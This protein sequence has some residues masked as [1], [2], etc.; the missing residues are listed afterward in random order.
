MVRLTSCRHLS[1]QAATVAA[2]LFSAPTALVAQ[3]AP[4]AQA[5]TKLPKGPRA[6]MLADWYRVVNVSSPAVS[7][8]GKRVAM[9]VTKAVEA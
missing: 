2:L 6:M 8:D 7:P 5:A 9:T 1:R 3:P 4:A